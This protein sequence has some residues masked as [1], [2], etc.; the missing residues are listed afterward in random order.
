[1][2]GRTCGLA[3]A[4]ALTAGPV[5][6]QSLGEAAAR[7]REK[8]AKQ[9]KPPRTYT[10]DDLKKVSGSKDGSPSPASST[11]PPP[12]ADADPEGPSEAE[13]RQRAA[14]AREA[15][16]EAEASVQR[17]QDRIDVLRLDRDPSRLG[18]PFRLQSIEADVA[19]AQR[20]LEAAKADVGRA[21]QA[22]ADL[23][24][25]AR[26]AGVPPGWLRD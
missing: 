16:A 20:E 14:K 24:D 7:E 21:K 11:A 18:D 13:W 22:V 26:R 25:E 12:E 3:L 10:N 1:M 17:I 6:G 8:R 2:N 19:K 23:E 4:V 9:A 15:V 5:L